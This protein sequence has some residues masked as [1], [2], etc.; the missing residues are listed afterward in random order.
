[1]SPIVLSLILMA[2]AVGLLLADLFLPT[3]GIVLIVA[4]ICSFASIVIAFRH[5]YEFGVGLLIFELCLVPFFT[6]VFVNVWPK[7][8]LGRRMIIEPTPAE[9]FKWEAESLV[10]KIGKTKCEMLPA[11]EIE[12]DGRLWDATSRTGLIAAGKL[13]KVVEEEMGQLYVIPHV[14]SSNSKSNNPSALPTNSVL[15]RPADEIGIDKL[16]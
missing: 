15:D 11:G 2:L 3:G 13:V 14:E 12:I 1:L 7:T 9:S 4:G 8:P 6:W 10:G 16:D 5:S